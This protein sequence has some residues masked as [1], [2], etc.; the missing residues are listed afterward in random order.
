MPKRSDESTVR[1]NPTRLRSLGAGEKVR[2]LMI[3]D[4]HP[5][6]EAEWWSLH[7]SPQRQFWQESD[8]ASARRAMWMFDRGYKS[9]RNNSQWMD[10][11][12]KILSAL[13]VCEGDRRRM[14][15]EVDRHDEQ[16]A[17]DVAAKYRQVFGME[18]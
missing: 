3:D 8:W 11:G 5:M 6:V 18:A 7:N 2:P 9:S 14:G 1:R 4:P 17:E 13:G 12:Q 16:P 15:I 10:V